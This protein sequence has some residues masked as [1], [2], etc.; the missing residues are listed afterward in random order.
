VGV[1]YAK[2][3]EAKPHQSVPYWKFFPIAGAQVRCP[4]VA[5]SSGTC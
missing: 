5:V 4:V 3:D 2:L 1:I